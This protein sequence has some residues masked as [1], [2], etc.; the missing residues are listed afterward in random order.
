MLRLVNW[1]SRCC[2]IL[3]SYNKSLFKARS[4]IVI[5]TLGKYL[6]GASLLSILRMRFRLYSFANQSLKVAL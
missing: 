3:A 5:A 6:V 1:V 4:F 2:A